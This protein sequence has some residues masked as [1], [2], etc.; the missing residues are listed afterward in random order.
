MHYY[1]KKVLNHFM[2]P[3]HLGKLKNADAIGDTKNPKCGDRMRIYLKAGSKG[4]DKYIKNI[5]FQTLGCPA[6]V[7]TTDMIC[8]L[9]KGKSIKQAQKIKFKHV[10]AK[11]G[12]L[13]AIKKH[14]A[15]LAETALQLA[16]KD[17][18][19]KEKAV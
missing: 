4:K 2:N 11:L 19:E 6:A 13:P 8:E 17:L 1:S 16:L 18:K 10:L 7:A 15:H 9:A 12:K 3:K 5:K 14:C